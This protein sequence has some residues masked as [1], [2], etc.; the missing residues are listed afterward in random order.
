MEFLLELMTE[1]LPPSHVRSALDQVSQ[2]WPGALTA[3][4]LV[5]PN[6]PGPSPSL[7]T[8]GTCRRLVVLAEIPA[9][10][11]E[12]EERVIGPPKAAAYAADGTPTAAA[13]GFAKSRG[14]D[15]YRLEVF[16]TDKGEYVGF[17][18]VA[19]GRDAADILP[20]VVVKILSGL[21]FPKMMRWGENPTRFSRPVTNILCLLDGRPLDFVFAGVRAGGATFGHKLLSAEP[22]EPRSFA[23]YRDRLA[24]SGVVLDQ[25]ERRASIVSQAEALLAPLKAQMLYDPELLARLTF[26]VE[27]PFVFLG[28]F[29][30]AYLALPLEILSTAMREGQRLFSVIKGKKQQPNFLG[31]ADA[32]DDAKSLIRSGNERV[33]KARLEDARF[34]WAEDVKVGL[35][36]RSAGLKKVVFQE[37]LGSYEDKSL[38]LKKLCVYLCDKVDAAEIKKDVLLAAELCKADLL[39]DMVGEFPSLQG[40][41]GGLLAAREKMGETAAKTIYEHYQPAGLDDEPPPSMGGAILSLADKLDSLAGVMGLG[42]ATTGSGDPFGLRRNAHGI[43]RIIL[44]RKFILNLPRLVDKALDAFVEKLSLRKAEVKTACLVFLAIRLKS[45]FEKQGYRY[46]LITAAFGAG[47]EDFYHAAL[48]L[49]ALHGLRSS[50]QFEPFILMAKRVNNI[51]R[52]QP[53]SKVNPGLFQEKEEKELFALFS[54]VKQNIGPMISQGDFGQAQ[55]M[56]FRL[57]P[58]LNAFFDK[59]LV[60]DKDL[61]LRRNRLGL[62][63]AIRKLLVQI[64]DYSQVVVEGERGAA[65]S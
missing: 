11:G 43:C 28:A 30:E 55:K 22:F 61:R 23:E 49:Q 38:R 6:G 53:E 16:K 9:G 8:Y 24:A 52:D 18:K 21:V 15:P 37:K 57:Q 36:K 39:T 5:Q 13:L 63:Q 41:M 27:H 56:I 29:P 42:I 40:R 65:T 51:L 19:R 1:E 25:E 50:P 59:V 58:G 7:K 4:G 32:R 45:I 14:V 34:F 2:A 64:A 20:E 62:L 26:D 60:M 31:V 35:K 47:P 48:R 44:D 17:T 46:D 3:A 10:P 12:R 54:L 33:L